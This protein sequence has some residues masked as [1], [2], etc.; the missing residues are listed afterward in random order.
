MDDYFDEIAAL[1][2]GHTEVINLEE[3]AAKYEKEAARRV[4]KLW[5]RQATC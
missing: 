2:Q 4:I 1:A 3:A 5:T